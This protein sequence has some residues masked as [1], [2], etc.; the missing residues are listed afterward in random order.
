MSVFVA[1]GPHIL[2]V[3][4]RPVTHIPEGQ[5]SALLTEL[6]VT[7]A[8]TAGGT[9]VD[10][11]RL[12]GSVRSVGAIGDDSAGA[13]LLARLA[14]VGVD[15]T[16]LVRVPGAATSATILPIRPN[17]ERPALHLPGATSMLTAAALDP[18]SLGADVLAGADFVHVGGPDVL[19]DFAVRDLPDLL[20]RAREAGTVVSADLLS[21]T[22]P[23]QLPTLAPV[24]ALVDHLLVNDQQAVGLTGAA[25][26][27]AAAVALLDS[28]PATVVVTCGAEGGVLADARGTWSFPALEV[29]VVDTTGCGDA[30]SAGYLVAL[31]QGLPTR[32]ACALGTCCA[33][34]VA[35]RLGSDGIGDLASATA[36]LRDRWDAPAS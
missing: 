19:G 3:L 21:V 26:P 11:A 23:A 1:L 27:A 8:G 4:G 34:L 5:G 17:G 33:A 18:A 16:G 31:S 14:E 12:G 32:D 2:D 24:L 35:Q 6:A 13:F 25:D 20:R 22:E 30:F 36:L 9:A 7:V 15:T 28:G 10:L 29:D